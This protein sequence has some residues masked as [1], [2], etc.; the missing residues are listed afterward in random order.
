V[1]AGLAAGVDFLFLTDH[2]GLEARLAG[3]EGWH[4]RLLLLVGEEVSARAGHCLALGTKTHINHR[5]PLPDILQDI[6]AQHGIS[7]VAHPH[8]VYRPL[9]KL[10]DHSWKDWRADAFTGL[11]IWS[12]MFDWAR[13]FRYHRFFRHYREP[14]RRIKG[15]LPV[16]IKTWD[17]LCRQRRVVGVGGVDAHAR[18]YPLFPFVVFPYEDLFRTIRTRVLLTEPLSSNAESDHK[19][20]L[21]ALQAGRCFAS[22]D[23]LADAAGTRFGSEDGRL[24]MGD[25]EPFTRPVRLAFTVPQRAQLVVRR[26]GRRLSGA[27]NTHLVVDADRA[28]VYRAEASIAG[29]PWIYTNPIYLR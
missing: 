2:N 18:R 14:D 13:D 22:Y 9:V 7:F 16:T 10:R 1:D 12:Y 15:P 4:D 11:E 26:D 5:Q 17:L 6:D 23:R 3:W 24:L 28:G 27:S 21:G 20:I 29:K 25:E 8:G 19:R